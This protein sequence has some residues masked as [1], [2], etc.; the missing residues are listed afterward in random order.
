MTIIR[1]P[2]LFS[3]QELY[4]MEPTQKYDTIISAIN[5]DAI[6]NEINK[7]SQL[8]AP[9]E[10]NYAAMAISVFVRYI[11][12]IPTIK[13][14]VKRLHHDIAFKINCGF[15]VSD[16]VPSEA[17]YSR[18]LTKLSESNVLDKVQEK[19]VLQANKEGYIIDDT[20][21]IDATHF[22]ARDQTPPKQDK[23][24]SEP[25]KR[26]RKPKAEREQWLKEKAEKEANL[27][28]YEKKIEDQLDV[29]LDELRTEIP[30]TPK[31]GVKKNS[32]GKNEFWFGYKGHL[33]VGTSSQ[34]I[35]QSFFSSGNLNDGKA[36]IPLLKGIENLKLSNIRYQTMD[37]GYD[38]E[39]IY[40]QV[41]RMGQQSVIAYNKRN[42][43]EPIGFNKHFAPT[44]FREHSYRYDSYDSK[45]ET[46]KYTSPKECID[47]PLATQD[48]CQKVFK[49]KVTKDLRKYTAPAR[50]SKAWQSI[51]NRRTAVE[52]VNA[53]LKEFFQLNNVRY[54][55]GKRAKVHFDI[56]TLVYN[57]SKLAVDRINTALN[58]QSHVA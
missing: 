49:M 33:A 53:Y 44:C 12:R 13:D 7:K 3:I 24:K 50:G 31:W 16:E 22:E 18:L 37:A 8:G 5:M 51:Y 14:L 45:Y 52:R 42:E 47:C 48:I 39:P 23:P 40:K 28:I 41:Y 57:A 20:I 6:Y 25:K 56:V 54:R 36:A 34:Y 15:L 35:L 21:A 10:L 27:P 26:G 38:Y 4:D 1:Q 32:E 55:T 11:E 2:S 17:S 9:T 29:P 19:L 30:Q 46:L 58:E 43:P